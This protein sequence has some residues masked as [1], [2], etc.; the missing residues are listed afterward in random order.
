MFAYTFN[1]EGQRLLLILSSHFNKTRYIVRADC[2]MRK[3][4]ESYYGSC[5][6]YQFSVDDEKSLG[7]RLERSRYR[8]ELFESDLSFL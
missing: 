6:N 4:K 2:S 3:G 7:Y 5:L 8:R 1:C